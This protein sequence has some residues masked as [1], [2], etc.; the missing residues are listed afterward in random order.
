MSVPVRWAAVTV[1]TI[2]ASTGCMSVGDD[3][4]RPGPS[5][6]SDSKGRTADP[7]DDTTAGSGDAGHRG[8][9]AHTH[10]DGDPSDRKSPKGRPS[11]EASGSAVPSDT[12]KGPRP[13]PGAPHP[14]RPGHPAPPTPSTPG[15]GE[16]PPVVPE[17]PAPQP[18]PDP[19]PDPEPEPTEPSE[20]PP[21]ASPA[22]QLRTQSM[23]G[24]EESRPLRTPEASPQV[25]PV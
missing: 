4:A 17:P 25:R 22:A 5:G 18:S 2:A 20:P 24:A 21:S 23:G 13:Q 14:P 8:G 12:S 19:D 1:L 9:D 10:S 15:P 11:P 3:G 7:D 6:S 16:P